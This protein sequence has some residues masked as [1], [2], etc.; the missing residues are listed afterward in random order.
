[1]VHANQLKPLN[2]CCVCGKNYGS[3]WKTF[4]HINKSHGRSFKACKTCLE[5]F[6]T[7]LELQ[8]HFEV[9]HG[10]QSNK[11]LNSNSKNSN[12]T[13]A[14]KDVDQK[15]VLESDFEEEKNSASDTSNEED[16]GNTENCT[17]LN[18]YSKINSELLQKKNKQPSENEFV[19]YEQKFFEENDF[20][21]FN[22]PS[23]KRR[24]KKN[25][26]SKNSKI[27]R[28]VEE[29]PSHNTSKRTVYVNSNDPSLCEICLRTWPAKKHLWQ[30]YI[31]CHKTEAATVCGICLKT[32]DNYLSLQK[33]LNE[34]H[35]TLL[36]GQ[37]FGSNFICRICGRY[38]NASSK[39]KLHMAIHENFDWGILQS[40]DSNNENKYK[41]EDQFNECVEDQ[42][43][44]L[45][46]DINYES[47]IEQVECSTD[48]SDN[49]SVVRNVNFNNTTIEIEEN[50]SSTEESENSSLSEDEDEENRDEISENKM[51]DFEN[52]VMSNS[53]NEK[54]LLKSYSNEKVI[55]TY[56]SE[57]NLMNNYVNE[58]NINDYEVEVH[59]KEEIKVEDLS[60]E[61]DEAG[62]FSNTEVSCSEDESAPV[63]G[64]NVYSEE[65]MSPVSAVTL[66]NE[67][68]SSTNTN[69]SNTFVC[70]AE[71]LDSA[72]RS[73]SYEQV[74]VVEA[75]LNSE[76]YEIP[77]QNLN[78]HE[79]QSA[80][81]SIL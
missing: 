61:E 25:K 67:Q 59:I 44:V 36:H 37:G 78:Q 72:I 64:V 9:A 51:N 29:N 33:H 54:K 79:I 60:S 77:V 76:Y 56:G 1:M 81:D 31:R 6:D 26:K 46:D 5:V 80:V 8:A 70:K 41:K 20:E 3:K 71:E 45:N 10:N 47:L 21:Q 22:A 69:D 43:E 53:V 75:D 18:F 42:S 66:M 57:D 63:K 13:D 12:D 16:L 50:A 48:E 49:E 34:N 27:K 65:E 68:L 32:N 39:L 52:G 17:D 40:D 19:E 28:E 14:K 11:N 4:D 24:E 38:H 74:E 58:N 73:I 55:T 15:E 23:S 2:S 7:E 30:H 35:P 62:E